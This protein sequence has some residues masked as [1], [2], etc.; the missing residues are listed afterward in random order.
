MKDKDIM[1][2][3]DP[4][5]NFWPTD[6]PKVKFG[7]IG[8][9]L[10]NL[11]TPDNFDYFSMRKYLS[12][13][14]SDK[15]VIDYPRW[16][17]QPLLQLIILS[18]R[19]FTSG[20]AYKEIWNHEL[21]ESP[22]LTFTREQKNALEKLIQANLSDDFFIEYCMRYGNPSVASKV[23][24]LIEKG[25]TR[26]LYFPLYPQYSATTTATACDDLWRCLL[27]TKWQ[28]TIR[29]VDPYFDDPVYIATLSQSIQKA[30]QSIE[31]SPELLLLSFHGLPKRYLLEGDPYHCHCQKTARLIT[32]TLRKDFVP[33]K[34]AFQSR[35]GTEEWL[36]PYTVEE[37][38]RLADNGVKRLAV[39]APGFASDCIETLEEIN[40]EIKEA[41][42]EAGGEQFHYIPSLN[43]TPEHIQMLYD[44]VYKNLLGW[45]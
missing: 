14:L 23:E 13:F 37:V 44:L 41:F 33:I 16:L 9:L 42:I 7:K 39:A 26:L 25:C 10:V 24:L 32:E 29:T 6:H 5:Q 34:V 20:S 4:N 3:N 8:I 12:Q 35:F 31:P 21:N 30:F 15:R 40:G 43:D 27:K 36:K 45:I 1:Q 11:G 19:P 2:T 38:A 22:L 28:P 18:K 17:W